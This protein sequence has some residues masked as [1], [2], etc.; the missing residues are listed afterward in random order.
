MPRIT[1]RFIDGVE[2]PTKGNKVH[3][4]SETKGFGIRITSADAKAFVLRYVINGRERRYTIGDYGPSPGLNTSAARSLADELKGAIAK[5]QDPLEER[6]S[7]RQAPTANDLCAEYLE[8]HARPHKRPKSVRDDESMIDNYIAKNL[9]RLKVTA[10][11]RRDIDQLHQ[12]LSQHPYRANRVLA[13][14][15]KMFSLAIEWEWIGRNP[16]KGVKRF[17]EEKRQRWLS[18][19]EL[20]LLT[21][22]LN[23]S[24]N[25]RAVNVIRLLTL[26]GARKS[27]ALKAEWSQI[28]FERGVWTKPSA[29][30]KQNR[31]E[32]VP[33]SA[34]ALALLS[35]IREEALPGVPF[36]FPGDAP[37]KPLQDFKREWNKIVIDAG[38]EDVRVHDLRHTYASHLVSSGL[39]LEIVGRLL[40]HTQP[41][42][43]H[44][45]AH[46]ADDPL[47]KATNRMAAIIERDGDDSS[48]DNVVALNKGRK[49]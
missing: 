49:A 36:I 48:D 29:H 23:R 42:T 25:Q 47:R 44:R 13:L 6:V 9:G 24:S 7:L 8:R 3:W 18:A 28:D 41:A 43:T 32:H 31:T 15:S 22:A 40:G 26:T 5:G 35:E 20:T 2:P 10:I 12:S 1:N 11:G 46:L 34:S 45:Y 19:D 17:P 14:L 39:S 38:L 30:T 4:D 16:V 33:L 27:E 21:D 37:G